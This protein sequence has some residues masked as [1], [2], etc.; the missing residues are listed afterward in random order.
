[1]LPLVGAVAV[2]L[3][4][5]LA[6]TVPLS[7]PAGSSAAPEAA[8]AQSGA[9]PTFSYGFDLAKQ[10]PYDLP[11]NDPGAVAS[12][13][14]VM[15]SSPMVEAQQL[16]GSGVGNPEASPGVY[17]F[18]GVDR[19]IHLITSTGGTPVMVLFGAPDWMKGQPAGT[20]NWAL[21]NEAPLPQYYQDFANL[22][23]T[24][25][26]RYP[27]VKYF[28]VW[29]EL[30]GFWIKS[31][32]TYDIASYTTMYNDVYTAI[33]AVRPDAMVGGPYTP[34]VSWSTPHGYPGPRPS[35]PW[36]YADWG[37]LQTI[38]YFLANAVGIDFLALDAPN[39]TKDKGLLTDPVTSDEK[40]AAIDQWIRSQTAIPMWWLEG[41][42]GVIDPGQ[43]ATAARVGALVDMASSGASV[44]MQWQPQEGAG[45]NG[46]GMWTSTAIPGGGQPT[47]LAELLPS[48]LHVLRY[49]VSQIAGQ[50]TGVVA[51]TGLGGT[52]AVNGTSASAVAD[53]GTGTVTLGPGGISIAD[54]PDPP[55]VTAAVGSEGAATVSFDAP[56]DAGSSPVTA[57]TVTAD[58]QTDPANGGQTASGQASPVTVT[59]LTD[60]DT[61]TFTVTATNAAGTGPPSAPSAAVVPDPPPPVVFTVLG[62]PFPQGSSQVSLLVVGGNFPPGATA[63]V[64]GGGVTLSNLAVVSPMTMEATA[65]VSPSA[66]TGPRNL[67]VDT[68]EGSATCVGCLTVS[69]APQLLGVTP[70]QIAQGASVSV[71]IGGSGIEPGA[72]LKIVGGAG[73]Q[74]ALRDVV[75]TSSTSLTAT[76]SVSTTATTG[77]DSITLTNPDHSTAT[78][79]GCLAVL[80]APTLTA[81]APSDVS[82]GQ[83]VSVVLSGTGFAPGATVTGPTG[84]AFS[85]V[86]V[87]SPDTIDATLRVAKDAPAGSPLQV[88]VTN[89]AAGGSGRATADLLTVT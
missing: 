52:V 2:A 65:S 53:L 77:T 70:A 58:D 20:T 26:L 28:V 67:V 6:V 81:I 12:A 43:L 19:G 84:T 16:M 87:Q 71:R 63:R 69:A 29:K 36:G 42:V 72:T 79:T 13:R 23:A 49:P 4:A 83:V 30:Q 60:G 82:P 54:T 34:L 33:K 9:L 1:V 24:V 85:G 76:V 55:V 68:P 18:G 17:T 32:G 51:V 44:G 46:E 11:G 10:G 59:G 15:A 3:A 74:V 22:A 88:K 78:C 80:A 38:P 35:G 73:G 66:A 41:P 50:P 56:A 47:L 14:A 62:G 5:S 40:F 37:M 45:I 21:Q 31:T 75:V 7:P 39:Y 27:Q 89:D 64:T 57:Y 48:L 61:Y 25:A 8:A 86:T